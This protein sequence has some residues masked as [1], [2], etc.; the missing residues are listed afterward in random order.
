MVLSE[1]PSYVWRMTKAK[2][3]RPRTAHSAGQVDRLELLKTFVR[4]V[5]A[6]SLS[7]A[8][9]QLRTTQPTVSRR[10]QQ[11]E[12][13]LDAQLLL[14]STHGMHLTN[15]GERCFERAKELLEGWD[16]F[17]WDLRQAGAPV[18]GALRVVV[19][20]VF[21]QKQLIGPLATF[22]GR[23]PGVRVDWLLKQAEGD[24]ATQGIDCAIHVGEVTEPSLVVIRVAEV[25]R[26]LVAA[27][28]LL[29]E[30]RPPGRPEDLSRLPWIAVHGFYQREISLRQRTGQQASVPIAPRLTT[31]SFHAVTNAAIAGIGAA[32]ISTWMVRSYLEN[33]QL[34]E[35]L[36]DWEA[37]A[38]PVSVVYPYAAFY[39]AR[40]RLFVDLMREVM[41]AAVELETQ[42]PGKRRK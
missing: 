13:S 39:P 42:E 17:E 26:K 23:H 20:H 15:D 3:S 22:M 18:G 25:P 10:L 41:P 27:P 29:A 32:M 6:G 2:Q 1:H 35:L 14:R 40:L 9:T 38:V 8:A 31:D 4:I 12:R 33:G 30:Q 36:P 7:A 11:L 5:Q 28:S 21:G 16:A 34:T 24:F 19:P 37:P